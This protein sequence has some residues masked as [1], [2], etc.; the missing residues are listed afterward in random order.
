MSDFQRHRPGRLLRLASGLSGTIFAALLFFVPWAGSGIRAEVKPDVFTL[1]AEVKRLEA[2][3]L[4]PGFDPAAIPVAIY[5]YENTY[6]FDFP[7]LPKNFHPLPSRNDVSVF[8]GR[9]A[10]VFG[11]RRTRLENIWVATFLLRTE[12]PLTG[13]PYTLAE[14]AGIVIHEKFHVFQALSHPDWRPNDAVLLDYPLDTASSLTLRTMEAG[15]LRRSVAAED[16]ETSAGWARSALNVRRQRLGALVSRHSVYERELAR[17]EGIAEYIEYFAAGR[18]PLEDVP[19]VGFA[20]KGVREA[21]YY[22]GRWMAGVLDRLDPGWKD[23]MEAGRFRFL[24]ERLEEV[25]RGGPAARGFTPFEMR[26]L[27]ETAAA[28]VQKKARE[29]RELLKKFESRLGTCVEF[30]AGTVPLR[31]EMFDPLS[32]EALEQ[33]KMMHGRWIVLKHEDG[34]VEIFGQPC[35]TVLNDEGR[36]GRLVCPGIAR[37][38]PV[39]LGTAPVSFQLDGIIAYFKSAWV[40]KKGV[41]RFIVSLR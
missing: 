17:F 12:S 26:D 10:T 8:D 38:N 4:W 36:I 23:D 41:D 32:M 33:G 11:N 22:E 37:R 18:A 39:R 16:D 28:A 2:A 35:M 3:L 13:K 29:R 40:T 9:H 25:L 7:G 5:D 24:E 27:R 31:L 20:P 19:A 30:V 14:M 34:V 15:A 21:G 1:M 6:L